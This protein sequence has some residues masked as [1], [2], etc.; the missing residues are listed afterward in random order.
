MD[1]RRKAIKA[2]V[3]Q[4]TRDFNISKVDNPSL[5]SNID[6]IVCIASTAIC[7]SDLHMYDGRTGLSQD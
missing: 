4:G 5:E 6:V 1:P 3:F 2:V 7:G